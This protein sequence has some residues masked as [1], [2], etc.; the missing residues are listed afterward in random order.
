MA[1]V[2]GAGRWDEARPPELWPAAER[3]CCEV[4]LDGWT[5]DWSCS[6]NAHPSGD[7]DE[8]TRSVEASACPYLVAVQRLSSISTGRANR[9]DRGI[10]PRLMSSLRLLF[11]WAAFHV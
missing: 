2:F 8:P 3:G 5:K 10:R 9:L 11:F 4:V 6:C 7:S 1:L